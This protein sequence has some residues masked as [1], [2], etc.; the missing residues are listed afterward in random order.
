MTLSLLQLVHDAEVAMYRQAR[1][2]IAEMPV[3][4]KEGREGGE[5]TISEVPSVC[6]N[7]FA[8]ILLVCKCGVRPAGPS[9]GKG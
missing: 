2:L 9:A 5:N 8:V 6:V 7:G 4:A 1:N 3:C